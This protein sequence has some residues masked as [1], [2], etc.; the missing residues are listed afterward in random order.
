V[1]WFERLALRVAL[2]RIQEKLMG[3]GWKGVTGGI[4][5]MLLG[6]GNAIRD[7]ADGTLTSDR[8]T[9]YLGMIAAGLAAFGIRRAIT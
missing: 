6:L 9:I 5:L 4:A 3:S 7:F 8:L 2:T 1:T